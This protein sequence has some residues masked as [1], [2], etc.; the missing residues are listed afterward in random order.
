M[1]N[2]S[3]K[4]DYLLLFYFIILLAFGLIMLASASAVIRPS[5]SYFFIRRQ[6]WY[7][8]LPGIIAFIFLAKTN[9]HKLNNLAWP[10][11]AFI[12]L[13]L[14]LVLIPGIGESYGTLAHS[15]INILNFSFQ[16]AE[17]AKLGIIVFLAAYLSK[18]GK[19]IADFKIGFLP[20]LILG[21]IP[22]GL[23]VIQP[24]I[25]TVAVLFAILFAMLYFAGARLWQIGGLASVGIIGLFLMVI[26]APY[27][28][29]RLKIFLH[30]ELDPQGRGYQMSQAVL[31]VGSGGMF[32]LGL[33]HSRQK[34]QYLPEVQ[35]DSIFAI[36]A[37]ELGF[38]VTI[39]F[40]VLLILI[41]CRSFMLAKNTT[42]PFG[43]LL[44]CG[45][46]SWFL[47]QSFM[48]IGA[49]VGIL[50]LTGLPLPFVSHGGTA[51][52]IS[53]AAVGIVINVSKNS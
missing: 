45:I 8:V 3:R 40:I 24:D 7:G 41:G 6:I 32:G 39:G 26:I 31:A 43:R 48:N 21:L 29:D 49:I 20:A 10:S 16:P 27:R 50:P 23:V 22:I 14:V 11:Y 4:A 25:G 47:F 34:Y 44:I 38:F 5:D 19:N 51:L 28:V 30:P 2:D 18:L 36:I 12:L 1:T 42:D 37:E 15:W 46:I 9:Y 17:F 52:F 35:A 33:G 13:L 53:M